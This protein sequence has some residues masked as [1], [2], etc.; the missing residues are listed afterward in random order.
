MFVLPKET[1]DVFPKEILAKRDKNYNNK[2]KNQIDQIKIIIQEHWFLK[3]HLNHEEHDER[4][5]YSFA[6]AYF[7]SLLAIAFICR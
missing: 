7:F 2:L 4:K 3:I 5:D 6:K 1:K